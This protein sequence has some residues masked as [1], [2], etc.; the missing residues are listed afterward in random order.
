MSSVKEYVKISYLREKKIV[1]VYQYACYISIYDMDA[2]EL[3]ELYKKR[4]TIETWIEQVKKH[5]MA[6]ST[7]TDDFWANDILWQLSVFAYNISVMMC[8]KK[9]KFK[10]QEQL[11]FVDWFI[12]VPARITR[13]GHQTEL[14][15]MNII[16]IKPPGKS[17]TG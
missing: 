13:S 8:Q 1:P 11:S 10:K 5:L 15:C 16:F 9:N 4:S 3:H 14:K 7:L 6:G 12:S 2:I 17:L